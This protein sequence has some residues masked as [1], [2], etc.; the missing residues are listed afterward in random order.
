MATDHTYHSSHEVKDMP[1]ADPET[2]EVLGR[3]DVIWCTE[4][5]EVISKTPVGE[6]NG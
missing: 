1:I 4:C 6:S 2:F 5:N 3:F